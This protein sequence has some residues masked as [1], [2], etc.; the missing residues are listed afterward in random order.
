M[1]EE[2][3]RETQRRSTF[4]L[5]FPPEY[6]PRIFIS[7]VAYSVVDISERGVRFNN[8]F[9]HRMPDDIFSAFVWFHDGEP[10]KVLARV[11]RI[12]P[13]RNALYFLQG[14]PYKRIMAEQVYVKNLSKG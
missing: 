3:S 9:R 14:I 8:P 5:V 7:G 10:V 4:R 2:T 1:A 11:V 6:S 12:E 13:G